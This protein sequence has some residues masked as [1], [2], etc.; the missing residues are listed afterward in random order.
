MADESQIRHNTWVGDLNTSV[1]EFQRRDK[2]TKVLKISLFSVGGI[3]TLLAIFIW[4]TGKLYFVFPEVGHTVYKD[5][6]VIQSD[7][8]NAV[9]E[10]TK[11][12][13]ENNFA[14]TNEKRVEKR[15]NSQI[16]K[17]EVPPA[18]P[19]HYLNKHRPKHTLNQPDPQPEVLSVFKADKHE[20]KTTYYADG[21]KW[22]ELNY[23]NGKQDG[24]QLGWYENGNS[25]YELN[26][27]NGKKDGKQ[28]WWDR[29]GKITTEKMYRNGEW[30]R[31]KGL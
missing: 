30:L 14:D 13:P 26:Y 6:A 24:K 1:E 16:I 19:A 29:S 20:T 21:N 18:T 9:I 12:T 2:W 22:L 11:I 5:H 31:K 27:V 23:A 3:V 10:Q 4:S 7:K 25:M 8:P 15:I 17:P 28:I